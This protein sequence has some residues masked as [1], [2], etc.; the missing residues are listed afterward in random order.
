[1][2]KSFRTIRVYDEVYRRFKQTKNLLEF[3]NKEEYSISQFLNFLL[4]LQLNE[5]KE[6]TNLK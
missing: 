6:K 1:M 3:Q 4:K 2:A 5:L